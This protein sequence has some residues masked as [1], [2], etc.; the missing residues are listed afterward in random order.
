MS[1][2]P[3]RAAINYRCLDCR[4][5][6]EGRLYLPPGKYQIDEYAYLYAPRTTR[7]AEPYVALL[8]GQINRAARIATTRAMIRRKDNSASRKIAQQ[9]LK[10]LA[11]IDKLTAW[12]PHDGAAMIAA[13]LSRVFEARAPEKTVIPSVVEI[14]NNIRSIRDW[15]LHLQKGFTLISAGSNR[16]D[17]FGQHFVEDVIDFYRHYTHKLPPASRTSPFA[18]LLA[19]AWMDLGL[20][21]PP[22]KNRKATEFEDVV[23]LFG[24]KV[25]TAIKRIRNKKMRS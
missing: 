25:E 9:L 22:G 6:K 23:S 1:A 10:T 17:L 2:K 13:D 5:D 8:R 11:R 18:S 4:V 15:H 14:I 24:F 20:P 16:A 7:N 21:T 3:K 19:A 12:L